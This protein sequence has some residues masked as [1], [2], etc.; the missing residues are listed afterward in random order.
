[1]LTCELGA[2]TSTHFF[3]ENRNQKKKQ[4]YLSLPRNRPRSGF[5]FWAGDMSA[6]WSRPLV[7]VLAEC[8]SRAASC[9]AG[10]RCHALSSDWVTVRREKV[11]VSRQHGCHSHLPP[12]PDSRGTNT[13]ICGDH[14]RTH[15]HAHT[16][17]DILI[18]AENPRSFETWV[19][20]L[21]VFRGC[22]YICSMLGLSVGIKTRT[23]P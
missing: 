1:M 11:T 9:H 13:L 18:P 22:F 10:L 5:V 4:V 17:T 20:M 21:F 3:A 15:V 12:L 2:V 7:K 8:R 14:T 23:I 6:V 19:C 16:H